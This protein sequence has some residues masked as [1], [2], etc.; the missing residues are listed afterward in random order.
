MKKENLVKRA[1]VGLVAL[2]ALLTVSPAFAAKVVLYAESAQF[3][4]G[5]S[6]CTKTTYQNASDAWTS[7]DCT[8]AGAN[9]KSFILRGYVPPGTGKTYKATLIEY[10][11]S[12]TGASKVCSWNVGVLSVIDVTSDVV[13]GLT[14]TA[15]SKTATHSTT[16]TY[17]TAESLAV[18]LQKDDGTGVATDC[19][20]TECND[21][22][23]R[24]VVTLNTGLTTA[25]DCKFKSLVL[26]F[27]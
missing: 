22:V 2:A 3:P 8:D 17:N 6:D 11:T 15:A 26:D 21:K 7:V 19:L 13:S 18:T 25:T 23:A 4:T 5:T 10:K 27:P 16:K 9:G 14:A 12:D 20:T 24:V 1:C